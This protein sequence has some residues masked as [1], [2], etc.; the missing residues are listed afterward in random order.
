MSGANSTTLTANADK[1]NGLH[2]VD[3][4][5]NGSSS[6]THSVRQN[7]PCSSSTTTKKNNNKNSNLNRNEKKKIER[8][9]KHCDK[10]DIRLAKFEFLRAIQSHFKT[11]YH[12]ILTA[13]L[14]FMFV[15]RCVRAFVCVLH[16]FGSLRRRFHKPRLIAPLFNSKLRSN[17]ELWKWF[18]LVNNDW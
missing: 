1:K 12:H 7:S 11:R 6:I 14:P 5:T 8:K 4:V 15:C 13:F 16:A 9:I 18:S 2:K 10:R 3:G 17:G